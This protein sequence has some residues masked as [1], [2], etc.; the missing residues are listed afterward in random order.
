MERIAGTVDE[1]SE[2]AGVNRKTGY[3]AA[4]RG[5]LKVVRIGKRII[6]PQ[7]EFDR[8]RGCPEKSPEHGAAASPCLAPT[9]P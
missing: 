1:W 8:L 7:S 5:E 4:K 3:D 6:V 9:N 2:A